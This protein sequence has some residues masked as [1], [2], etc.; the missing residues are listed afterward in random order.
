M[1]GEGI[2]VRITVPPSDTRIALEKINLASMDLYK[3][4]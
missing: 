1:G 2:F 4:C 3:K